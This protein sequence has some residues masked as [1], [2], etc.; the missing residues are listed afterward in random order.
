MHIYRDVFL[1]LESDVIWVLTSIMGGGPRTVGPGPD[2]S[3]TPVSSRL[4]CACPQ[5]PSSACTPLGK[6]H[7]HSRSQ[8]MGAI[9]PAL[10]H[11]HPVL[12]LT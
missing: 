7:R 6:M 9:R 4:T 2:H 5:A 10:P 1:Y 3:G 12:N 11:T 8:P